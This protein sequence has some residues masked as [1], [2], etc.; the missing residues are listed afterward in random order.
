MEGYLL[1]NRSDVIAK[2]ENM[3]LKAPE[4]EKS[5]GYILQDLQEYMEKLPVYDLGEVI[6]LIL[7]DYTGKVDT[8]TGMILEDFEN[9]DSE[10]E[11]INDCILKHCEI[12]QKKFRECLM[13]RFGVN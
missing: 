4:Q 10:T 9:P 2:I 1:I 3:R 12:I 8:E 7:K 11:K 5:A 13:K 6:G